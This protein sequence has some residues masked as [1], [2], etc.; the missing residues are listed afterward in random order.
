MSKAQRKRETASKQQISN[1]ATTN[2]SMANQDAEGQHDDSFH[3]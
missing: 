2:F 3:R 1:Q